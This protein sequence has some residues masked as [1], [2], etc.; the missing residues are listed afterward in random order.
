MSN[1]LPYLSLFMSVSIKEFVVYYLIHI[2][3]YPSG[4]KHRLKTASSRSDAENPLFFRLLTTAKF[5]QQSLRLDE[6]FRN[7]YPD[8]KKVRSA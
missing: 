2:F 4:G 1:L 5:H 6:S 8:L 3:H 7:P